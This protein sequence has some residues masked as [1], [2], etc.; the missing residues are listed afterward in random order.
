M[1]P[2][3]AGRPSQGTAGRLSNGRLTGNGRL[4]LNDRYHE[5]LARMH[6]LMHRL[7]HTPDVL[8]FLGNENDVGANR[9]RCTF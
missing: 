7:L 3:P 2:R 6:R 4:T 5:V 8:I 1:D 9:E